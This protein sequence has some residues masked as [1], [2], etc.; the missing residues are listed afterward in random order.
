L[1]LVAAAF[2]PMLALTAAIIGWHA[3]RA[4]PPPLKQLVEAARGETATLLGKLIDADLDCE[5]TKDLN[6][7]KFTIEVPGNKIHT[8]AP[9]VGTRINRKKP[10]H[11][12]PMALIEVEG[13]FAA[14]VRVTGEISPGSIRPDDLQGNEIPFTFQGAGLVLYEDKDNFV[15][16]E[17]T[18]GVSI[19]SLEQ[20]RKQLYEVVKSGKAADSSYTPAPE[21]PMYLLLIRRRE[22]VVCGSSRDLATPFAPVKGIEG[23]QLDLPSRVRIGLS[24]SNISSQPFIATFEHFALLRDVAAIDREFGELMKQGHSTRPNVTW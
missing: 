17:R 5:F 22:R 3:F 14:V 13:D 11:N 24:A 1:L 18:A 10:L 6:S 23:I 8:L 2:V 9:Q 15:R 16:L 20:I 4:P 7:L 21:G 19:A 12:A